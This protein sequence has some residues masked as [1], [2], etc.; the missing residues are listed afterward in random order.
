MNNANCLTFIT[1]NIKGI[2]NNSKQLSVVEYF[3]N[4]LGN[5]RILFLQETHSTLN[6]EI[7]WQMTSMYLS[8]THMVPLNPVMSSLLILEISLFQLTNK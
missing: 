1:N 4:K 7:F 8:F 3:K 6:D 5:N 2:P